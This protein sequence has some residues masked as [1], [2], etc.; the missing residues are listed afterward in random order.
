M[1]TLSELKELFNNFFDS[2]KSSPSSDTSTD[3]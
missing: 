2:S 3:M 1:N